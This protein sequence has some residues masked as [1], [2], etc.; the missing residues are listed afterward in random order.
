MDVPGVEVFGK[1]RGEYLLPCGFV[2]PDGK[3][4]KKIVLRET[5]G[6][7]EDMMDDDSVLRSTRITNVLTAC[8]EQLGPVTDKKLIQQILSDEMQGAGKGV[9]S[10]DRIASMIFLRRTSVGDVYH[11]ERRCP[12]IGCGHMNKGKTLD[13]RTIKMTSVPDERVGKRR[14]T[15][16]LPR[17]G[18]PVTLR[19]MT[20]KHEESLLKLRPTQKDLRSAAMCARVEQIGDEVF[21]DTSRAMLAVKDLPQQDRNAIRDVYDKIEADVDT[22]I[23]VQ[24]DNPVCQAEFEFPLDIG[25]TFFS[26]PAGVGVALESLTWL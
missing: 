17:S 12:R 19:V 13:L 4:H 22:T 11:F 16:T 14:V 10:T 5:K 8:V 18:K 21:T 24:C 3:V 15:F 6:H 25:Q 9:T 20:A 23:Q 2:M 1:G 7:E 26:N